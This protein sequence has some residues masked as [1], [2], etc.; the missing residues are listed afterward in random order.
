MKGVDIFDTLGAYKIIPVVVL[1]K[2][3]SAQKLGD[4]LIKHNLACAEITFRTEEAE[5]IISS[6]HTNF[7]QILVGAGTVLSIE[8]AKRAVG[9][10]ASFLVSPGFDKTLVEYCLQ[11]DCPII[12][13]VATASEIQTAYS[14]G[15]HVLKFFPAT[16]LGG[17]EMIKALSAPFKKVRFVPTGGITKENISEFLNCKS[18]LACGG[19]WLVK[20]SLLDNEQFDTIDELVR[21]AVM[22]A[23]TSTPQ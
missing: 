17:V 22:L 1:E 15:L 12:P 13:G 21:E 20:K 4:I 14:M 6:L 19:T 11:N 10:G 7:P 18:V 23:K 5:D 3:E 8:Q 16:L 9:A 2:I